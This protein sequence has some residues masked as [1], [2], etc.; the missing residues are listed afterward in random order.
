MA[1]ALTSRRLDYLANACEQNCPGTGAGA[2]L[3]SYNDN[4]TLW[5]DRSAEYIVSAF[6][7]NPVGPKLARSPTGAL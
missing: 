7:G 5:H 2:G 3:F 1:Y 6:N 4:G